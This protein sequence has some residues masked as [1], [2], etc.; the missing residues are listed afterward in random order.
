M[1]QGTSRSVGLSQST[2][3]FAVIRVRFYV[4]KE[5]VFPA[6]TTSWRTGPQNFQQ[7]YGKPGLLNMSL[8]TEGGSD[9][10]ELA[11]RTFQAHQVGNCG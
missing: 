3:S 10:A 9:E 4:V 11:Q 5:Q 8:N 1:D 7:V 2:D 6:T